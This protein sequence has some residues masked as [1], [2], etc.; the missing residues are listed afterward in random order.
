ML[1]NSSIG[2]GCVRI[3]YNCIT[4]YILTLKNFMFKSKRAIF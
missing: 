1:N 3:V 4:L 2:D